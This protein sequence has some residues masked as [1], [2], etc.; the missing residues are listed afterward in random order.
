MAGGTSGAASRQ[1]AAFRLERRVGLIE[2]RELLWARDPTQNPVSMGE[3]PE[4][5]HD[6]LVSFGE[7]QG[8][9][10]IE[11]G[12]QLHGSRLL[13]GFL[14]VLEGHVQKHSALPVEPSV[15][16]SLDR[17]LGERQG[18]VIACESPS[19]VAKKIA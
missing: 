12:K 5:V 8:V 3:S 11:G 19:V 10:V 16:S 6:L 14:A 18:S 4:P 7:S 2:K 9:R 15:E 13:P 1:R 17:R